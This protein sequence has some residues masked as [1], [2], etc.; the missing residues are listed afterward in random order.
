MDYG[1]KVRTITGLAEFICPGIE[2]IPN[3]SEVLGMKNKL[4]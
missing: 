2:A 3:I 1:F 4:S